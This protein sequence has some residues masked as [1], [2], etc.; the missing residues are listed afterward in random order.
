MRPTQIV[1]VAELGEAI[2]IRRKELGLLQVDLA[3]Q[4]GITPATLSAIENG[5]DN[6]RI[7]LVMQICRDL[8]LHL[9]VKA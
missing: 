7:G 3:M 8:G 5:K 2:R 4:S 9:D 1:T 6:A